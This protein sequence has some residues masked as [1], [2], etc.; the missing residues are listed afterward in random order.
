MSFLAVIWVG[1][2]YETDIT[3]VHFTHRGRENSII[4]LEALSAYGALYTKQTDSTYM[5]EYMT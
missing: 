1:F 2:W 4:V 3:G 5:K